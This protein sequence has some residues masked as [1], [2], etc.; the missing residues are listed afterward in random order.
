MRR[1]L[2]VFDDCADQHA[3]QRQHHRAPERRHDAIDMES[4][5]N[6]RGQQIIRPLM[7]SR[8]IPSVRMLKGIVMIL[9]KRPRVALS[10]PMTTAAISAGIKPAT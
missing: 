9:S 1:M 7:T 10:R 6:G 2:C 3:E 4:W 5:D 8:K